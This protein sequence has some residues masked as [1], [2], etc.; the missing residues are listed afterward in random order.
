MI[1]EMVAYEYHWKAGQS[2]VKCIQHF[3][4]D[5][6]LTSK[7]PDFSMTEWRCGICAII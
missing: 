2:F 6:K 3:F 5:K 1:T 7:T 4:L